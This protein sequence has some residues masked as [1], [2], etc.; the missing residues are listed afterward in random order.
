MK[1]ISLVAA[2]IA[3]GLT[4]ATVNAEVQFSGFGT[5]VGGMSTKSDVMVRDY[6]DDFEFTTGS[7]VA[8]QAYS[9]LSDGLSATAQ[10]RSRGSDN[11]DPEFTWAYLSYQ[12]KDNWRI[13]VGRQRIPLYLY[14]DYL[15]VSYAY[16]WIAPPAE[17]YSAPFDSFDG[18]S[19]IHDIS[20][21]RATLNLRAYYGQEENNDGELNLKIDKI[22]SV[23]A[24]LNYDW[25]TVRASYFSFDVSAELGLEPIV[26]LWNNTPFPQVGQNINLFEDPAKGF[27]A[28][29]TFDNQD[30][31]FVAEYINTNVDESIFGRTKPWMVSVGKRFDKL[32]FHAT[33]INEERT[34]YDSL[35]GVPLGVSA[36]L[37]QLYYTSKTIL[38]D[39]KLSTKLYTVGLR[40]DFHQ[41]AAFK[42][43]YTNRNPDV[44]ESSA[45]LQTALVFVF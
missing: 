31:L 41:S 40:W 44:G 22:F 30:W 28:G 1:N 33:Y 7:F 6:D 18:I 17:V 43:D 27:E 29:I 39:F 15:D 2:A 23:T 20:F 37:D 14:S 32:M 19:T 11:W 13:Q 10:I 36:E 4:T 26:G 24:S 9:D 35:S 42:L 25:W 5:L 3:C 34:P 12:V 45:L 8:L 38:D 21:D 16:H